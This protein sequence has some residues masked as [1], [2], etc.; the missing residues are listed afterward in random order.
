M[1]LYDE[2]KF[3][4]HER[5]G[6]V[7]VSNEMLEALRAGDREAFDR[8]YSYF[9]SPLK[10]FLKALLGSADQA[11]DVCQE[12]F[13]RLW[14]HRYQIDPG[15]NFRSYLYTVAKNLAMNNLRGRKVRDRY[16]R[17][18]LTGEEGQETP[19]EVVTALETE[20]L[21]KLIVSRMPVR[22]KEVFEMSRFEGKSNEE[23]ARLLNI[24]KNA[25]EKHLSFAMKELRSAFSWR[26]FDGEPV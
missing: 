25:V 18:S 1:K 15:K 24:K 13:T 20:L 7:E 3:S 8:I 17:C 14:Q 4:R 11:E 2:R 16:A 12:L 5:S 9:F 10:V 22:R 19:H 21:I 26:F 6:L 23:I